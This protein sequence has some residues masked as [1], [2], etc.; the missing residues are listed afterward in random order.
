MLRSF[1]AVAEDHPFPIQ[2][3]PFGVF[4]RA[5]GS[6]AGVGVRIG[7]FVLDCS[8]LEERR[9]F[10]GEYLAGRRPF[11]Q[12]SLN[13]FMGL[14][15][16][17]WS[18]ARRTIQHLL[19][20]RT[21]TL[22]DDVALRDQVVIPVGDVEM[23]MPAQIGDYTDFYASRQHATNVGTMFR[24]ADNAL[25]PNWLH[26]PVGYHGRASS[27]VPSG[28]NVTRPRGQIKPEDGPPVFGPSRL[29]D[30]ELEL[31]VFVGP[32]NA[33]GSSIP[34]DA[35]ADH[36]FGMSLLNDWSARDIQKWEYVPLGPFLGKSFATS[37][38]PWITS[39]EALEPFKVS[40]EEQAGDNP[41]VLQYLRQPG[42]RVYNLELEVLLATPEMDQP[43]RIC[44]SNARNLY[45][46]FDQQ[47][48]H[49]T[50]NGCNLRPGDLLGSG[51]I[52]GD[53]DDSYGSLLELSWRGTRPLAL[54][55]G[56]E[57][58][59]LLDGDTV[60]MRGWGQADGYRV[61]L[62]EVRGTII[63]ALD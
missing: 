21:A 30:F 22:R 10:R 19:D 17:A 51:T 45:W 58:R 50:V 62:G 52:S 9:L 1:I 28:T 5:G 48:A 61:G 56:T 2:N 6:M 4:R 63:P 33:L 37:I 18:E 36:L 59:F 42:P 7:D 26:L 43:V 15:R 57:R 24:G 35:T 49:H 46:S 60:I 54:P 47:M 39:M 14:G 34:I 16:S 12:S 41:E 38:S 55:D 29:L 31:G 53:D 8:V 25:Q 11:S 23:L 3:L 44:H 13:M 40:G 27:V 20:E 32:G